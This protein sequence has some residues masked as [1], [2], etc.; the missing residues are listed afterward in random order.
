MGNGLS[1][2]QTII[3]FLKQPQKTTRHEYQRVCK[4]VKR[5]SSNRN[6]NSSNL[7]IG[8]DFH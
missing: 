3:K 1:K 6:Y 4:Q 7:F 2:I 5:A 8:F